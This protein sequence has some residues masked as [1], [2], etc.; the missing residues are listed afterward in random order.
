MTLI[1]ASHN[2]TLPVSSPLHR[3]LDIAPTAVKAA[4][5]SVHV[6]VMHAHV[7]MGPE[8]VSN[9]E[10]MWAKVQEVLTRGK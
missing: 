9:A 1:G 7:R 8:T 2:I 6:L 5:Y 4:V 3:A 10:I